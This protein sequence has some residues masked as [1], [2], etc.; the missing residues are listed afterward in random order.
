[1]TWVKIDDGFPRHPKVLKLPVSAK[2]AFVEALCYCGEFNTDGQFP[3]GLMA[4]KDLRLLIAGGLVYSDEGVL[5]IHD[6]LDY[7]PSRESVENDRR[8][9][10]ERRAKG[11][12]RSGD[13]RANDA[14]TSGDAHEPRPDPTRPE[15][16]TR[17]EP[18]DPNL[19][20]SARGDEDIRPTT[21]QMYLARKLDEEWGGRG[22]LT[23]AALVKLNRAHGIE[24]VTTALRGTKGFP[25]DRAGSSAY[26]YI[27][28]RIL[29]EQAS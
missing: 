8:K 28:A 10:R 27:E 7:N 3:V 2:W 17:T 9:A 21:D 19:A 18:Q 25:P 23:P 11:G 4:D 13:V 1:V 22:S 29:G 12:K 14:D 24:P 5:W 16:P 20:R 15:S 26:G 6:Y